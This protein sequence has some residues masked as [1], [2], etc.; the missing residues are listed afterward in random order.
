[1]SCDVDLCARGTKGVGVVPRISILGA[2]HSG[3]GGLEV[4]QVIGDEH[5]IVEQRCATDLGEP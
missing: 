3:W 5:E 4:P 2:R 1:M